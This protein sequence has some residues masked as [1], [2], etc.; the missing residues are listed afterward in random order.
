LSTDYSVDRGYS[1]L[2]VWQPK[3]ALVG[4]NFV[5]SVGFIPSNLED[6]SLHYE[7]S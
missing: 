6:F 4:E 3:I 5:R 2:V 7:P 1:K